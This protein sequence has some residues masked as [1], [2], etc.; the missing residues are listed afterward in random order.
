V[1]YSIVAR[2]P[3]TGEVGVAVQSH[4][5]GVGA[6]VPW[7]QPGAGA[8]ATQSVPEVAF[9]PEGLAAMADGGDAQEVLRDLVAGDPAA[10]FRQV[11]IVDRLGMARSYTGASC[12]PHAGHAGGEGFACQANM[13]ARDTVPAAMASAYAGAASLRFPERLLA[14]LDAAEAEGGDVRGRQSA[15]LLVADPDG[16]PWERSFDLRVEDHPDPLAELRRLVELRRAYALADRG[17]ALSGQG[18]FE[19]AA[20]AYAEAAA[21]APGNAELLFFAGIGAASAGDLDAAVAQI[22]EAVAANPGLGEVL[23]RVPEEMS[24]EAPKLRKRIA[25]D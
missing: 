1:T 14:T 5:F 23:H 22:R 21:A 3:D 7:V 16:R 6:I 13:M 20:A 18:R 15:A 8:V 24:P 25:R 2:D 19:E 12:I 17:D 4:W 9:G 10:A 11:G